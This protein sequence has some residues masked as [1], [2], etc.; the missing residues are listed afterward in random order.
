MMFALMAVAQLTYYVYIFMVPSYA[1]SEY[2]FMSPKVIRGIPRVGS[3]C[4][5]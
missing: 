3:T 4:D 2:Q 1:E 5:Y